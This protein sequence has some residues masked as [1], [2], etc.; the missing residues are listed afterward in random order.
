MVYMLNDICYYFF[1]SNVSLYE[2]ITDKSNDILLI[3]SNS[4]GQIFRLK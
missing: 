4:I 1:V 3:F 2:D